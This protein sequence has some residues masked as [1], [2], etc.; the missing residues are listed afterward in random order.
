M[1]PRLQQYAALYMQLAAFKGERTDAA[2]ANVFARELLRVRSQVFEVRFPEL[3]A[4]RLMA[5]N[6]EV[7]E[8]DEEYTFRVATEY[9]KTALGS[10]YS[11]NAPRADV[12]LLEAAPQRIRP[13]TSSYG[14]SFHE[15]RVAAR[16]GNQLPMRKANA[17]RK[18]VAQEINRVLSFG[19]SV[20]Y[21][22]TLR[23]MLTLTAESTATDDGVR[24]YTPPNGGGGS[25][26]WSLK[27]PDEILQDMN[28]MAIKVVVDSNDVEHP[29]AMLLPLGL[30]DH[31]TRTRLGDGSDATILKHFL[32][33]SPYIKKVE[34][35]YALDAAPA[36]QWTGTRT[37]VYD[38]SAECM[39][40]LLPVEFEQF[41]PQIVGMETIVGAHAR[42]GG[43]V[44]Y[45]PKAICYAD[46]M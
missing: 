2:E 25:P 23:G 16:T 45:R 26:L 3:K 19:D 31:V 7:N 38:D 8:T 41:A 28:G 1:D 12:S 4:T 18:A 20:T 11:Q 14:Y 39:D 34:P 17:S 29:N 43:V 6:T 9:G 5:R 37:M 30:H 44:V 32:A 15:A 40:Y 35:W 36:G 33:N 46:G 42:V 21:G 24:I 27:T 13:I 22:A 10:S